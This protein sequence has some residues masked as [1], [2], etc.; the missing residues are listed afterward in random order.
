M[1]EGTI[2]KCMYPDLNCDDM[3]VDLLREQRHDFMNHIQVIWGYLQLN[4]AKHAVQY[5]VEINKKMESISR[6]FSMDSGS[7]SLFLY[8]YFKKMHE[9]GL[10]IEF[11]YA[12]DSIKSEFIT[13]MFEDKVCI[14]NKVFDEVIERSAFALKD[15]IYIDVTQNGE[16]LEILIANTKCA[17]Y[18]E[19]ISCCDKLNNHISGNGIDAYIEADN[20]NITAKIVLRECQ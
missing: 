9:K 2:K 7:L 8:D 4:K 19:K 3:I 10:L 18:S 14:I 6:L 15:T 12:A 16:E 11:N 5:I 13:S 20:S 17:D 1:N